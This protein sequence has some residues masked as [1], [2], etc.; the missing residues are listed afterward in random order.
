MLEK[1]LD[2]F[3]ILYLNEKEETYYRAYNGYKSTIDL[4][5]PNLTKAPEYKLNKEYD[6]PI[7]I[8]DEKEVSTKQK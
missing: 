8:E 6:F 2:R 5:L 7:I 1:I 4:P 3:N